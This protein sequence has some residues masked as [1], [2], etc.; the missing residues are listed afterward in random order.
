MNP[1]LVKGNRRGPQLVDPANAGLAVVLPPID[2]I[3]VKKVPISLT[4]GNEKVIFSSES[5][6]TQ[7]GIGIDECF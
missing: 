3:D 6:F 5:D 2:G 1:V 4:V 7:P